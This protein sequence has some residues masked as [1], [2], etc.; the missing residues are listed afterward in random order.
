[1]LHVSDH[2]YLSDIRDLTHVTYLL[3]I[4]VTTKM[5]LFYPMFTLVMSVAQLPKT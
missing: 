3:W 4:S 1:M 2:E 5:V